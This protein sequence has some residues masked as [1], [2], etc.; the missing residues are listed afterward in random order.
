MDPKIPFWTGGGPP[1]LFGIVTK[2]DHFQEAKVCCEV[3]TLGLDRDLWTVGVK[4]HKASGKFKGSTP[5]GVVFN[6]PV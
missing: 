2:L 3:A 4:S 1:S 6:S 5:N